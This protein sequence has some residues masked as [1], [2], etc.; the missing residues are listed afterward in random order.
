MIPYKLIYNGFSREMASAWTDIKARVPREYH[1]A[2]KEYLSL[3]PVSGKYDALIEDNRLAPYYLMDRAAAYLPVM[4]MQVIERNGQRHMI[5]FREGAEEADIRQFL[6]EGTYLLAYPAVGKLT[7]APHLIHQEN[8]KY[9]LDQKEADPAAIDA[10]AEQLS[11]LNLV[12]ELP[13]RPLQ[14]ADGCMRLSVIAGRSAADHISTLAAYLKGP[15]EGKET[16]AVADPDGFVRVDTESGATVGPTIPG[17]PA[18]RQI[19]EDL[20]ARFA[21]FELLG[22]DFLLTENGPCLFE[23]AA[24]PQV[25]WDYEKDAALRAFVKQLKSGK[26]KRLRAKAKVRAVAKARFSATA[27]KRGYLGFMYKNWL[28]DLASDW[29]HTKSTSAREKRW[30]H[31]RGFLSFRIKQYGLTGKNTGAFLADRDYR[32]LRPL[33]NAFLKWVYDKVAM[34]YFLGGMA[35]YMPAYYYHLIYRHGR[36]H[37]YP[38]PDLPAGLGC[39]KEGIIGLL[40]QKGTLIVKPSEGS[41]GEGILKLQYQDGA[42]YLNNEQSSK[43]KIIA[44]LS[45]YKKNVTITEYAEMHPALRALYG[46]TSYTIRVMVLNEHGNDPV[47]ADAYL[48]IAA[49]ATGVTDNIADGGI[50]AVV[51]LATGTISNPEQII[52]HIIKPCPVHPDTGALI[53][54]EVPHWEAV[55]EGITKICHYFFQLEYMGFDIILTEDGFKVIEINTH[56]DLHRYPH[57]DPRIHDYFM[58]KKAEKKQA[59]S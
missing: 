58:R 5:P 3:H 13:G 17:Y 1:D 15:A 42:Y 51:D 54:G 27:E 34:R 12:C 35:E 20:L 6:K 25:P 56:Q 39:D 7:G 18:A 41:H 47:I 38:M 48:R 22:A 57:Y 28:R 49:D 50:C 45:K 44:R 43:E 21:E 29:R 9:Y 36:Q 8:G 2:C 59:Q 16:S 33:N 19:A 11:D 31:K 30:A 52:H 4:R 55:K 26:A 37:C 10:F 40:Q 24:M 32:W 23:L 53:E 14:M 46:Q